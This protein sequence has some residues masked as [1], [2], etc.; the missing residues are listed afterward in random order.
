[1]LA[2]SAAK[3]SAPDALGSE[4]SRSPLVSQWEQCSGMGQAD[5]VQVPPVYWPRTTSLMWRANRRFDIASAFCVFHWL[6]AQAK[7]KI[8]DIRSTQ[9]LS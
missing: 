4:L 9:Y 7:L 8:L 1:M 5:A 6:D 2:T 3:G